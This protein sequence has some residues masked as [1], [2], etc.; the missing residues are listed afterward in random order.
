MAASIPEHLALSH[1]ASPWQ[2]PVRPHRPAVFLRR[3][4]LAIVTARL[5]HA[6]STALFAFAAQALGLLGCARVLA[7]PTSLTP[8]LKS[9]ETRHYMQRFGP[10]ST[11]CHE[12]HRRCIR[13][14]E[15]RHHADDTPGAHHGRTGI[16]GMNSMP[17]RLTNSAYVIGLL[18][19]ASF[20]FAIQCAHA[21]PDVAS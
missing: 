20:V 16:P 2:Y 14:C 1:H 4:F 12:V 8:D 15:R 13:Q 9:G 18:T 5:A 17:V 21:R 6:S 19:D 10:I 3:L 11:L 7:S